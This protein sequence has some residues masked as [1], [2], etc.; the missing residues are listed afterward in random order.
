MRSAR[1]WCIV[2]AGSNA[3]ITAR[4]F[5]KMVLIIPRVVPDFSSPLGGELV[6]S[7][8]DGYGCETFSVPLNPT[9]DVLKNWKIIENSL[10]G[11]IID[12]YICQSLPPSTL[13]PST[14]LSTYFGRPVHLVMKGPQPRECAPTLGVPGLQATTLFQDGF[15]LLIASEESLQRLQERIHTAAVKS[16]EEVHIGGLDHARWRD[17]E[18][19]MERF[20]P[21]IVLKGAGVPFAEDMWREIVVSPD[22]ALDPAS[23]PPQQTITLVS[24]CT[25]CLLPNVDIATGVRDAAVPFKVLMKFRTGKDPARMN[26]S[27][28]GCNAVYGGEGVLHVGDWVRVKT[29]AG[30]GGV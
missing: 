23:A 9:S 5:G 6:I 24:K 13:S 21:N 8:P 30:G 4:E 22:R 17:G 14:I 12:G 10:W 29:W 3:V 15:P 27:C 28:F 7:F 1:K 19:P 2:D 18:L 26:Q 20:R 25:R 11:T 16:P